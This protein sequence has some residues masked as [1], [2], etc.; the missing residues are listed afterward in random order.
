MIAV[1]LDQLQDNSRRLESLD[2]YIERRSDSKS[3]GAHLSADEHVKTRPPT[4]LCGNQRYILRFV[5]RAVVHATGHCDVELA[6]QVREL[7]IAPTSDDNPIQFLHHGRG[8]K[9]LVRRQTCQRAAIYVSNV[10]NPCLQRPQVHTRQLFPNLRNAI[11]RKSAQLNLLPRRDVQHAIPNSPRKLSDG[12]QLL[13][14]HKTVRHAN[15]HHELARRWPAVENSHPLQQFL[16]RW[17]QCLRASP[18]D[19]RQ[20]L[21]NAQSIPTH[22]RLITLHRIARSD[23]LR[24]FLLC[25]RD[26]LVF[27]ILCHDRPS[28]PILQE[29]RKSSC[30][31]LVAP[32]LRSHRHLRS[33]RPLQGNPGHRRFLG[34]VRHVKRE[35]C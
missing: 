18:D 28:I 21:K 10:I 25:S 24:R 34:H 26:S 32:G 7:R 17:R 6:R 16:F 13:A 19:L 30:R 33:L 23:Y 14:S 1:N 22:R 4:L 5:M 27:R 15:T 12:A 9:Q 3:S 35:P 2:K 31:L 20:V 29:F 11:Q 8:I